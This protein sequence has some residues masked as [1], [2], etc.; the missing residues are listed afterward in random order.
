MRKE[1]DPIVIFPL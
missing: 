1:D